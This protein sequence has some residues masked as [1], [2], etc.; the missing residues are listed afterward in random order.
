MLHVTPEAPTSADAEPP[1]PRLKQLALKGSAYEIASFGISQAIRLGSNILLTRL[2]APE[3]FGLA[4]MI[5]MVNYGLIMLSDLGTGPSVVQS[6]HGDEPDYLNTAWTMHVMRGAALFC[7]SVLAAWPIAW[8]YD[9]PLLGPVLAV[10]SIGVLF[11]GFE[12]TALLTLLRRVDSRRLALLDLT[13]Q[14]VGIGVTIIGAYFTRSVWAIVAGLLATGASKTLL[15]HFYLDVGY[16]NRFFWSKEA[17]QRIVRFGRWIFFASLVTFFSSQVDRMVLGKLLGLAELGVYAVA[18]SLAEVGMMLVQRLTSQILFPIL[19]RVHREQPDRVSNVFYRARL[20]LDALSLPAAGALFVLA[21]WVIDLLYDD[22]Y[23]DASWMLSVLTLRITISCMVVPMETCLFALGGAHFGLMKS[24]CKLGAMAVGLPIGYHYFGLAGIV[25]ATA[26]S[27]LPA[28]L[29]L[30][31]AFARR[32][33]LKVHREL[34]VPVLFTLGVLLGY[35]VSAVLE[36][37]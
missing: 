2:L 36:A 29:V 33:L 3:A 17:A 5:N 24:L 8:L 26:L 27:D 7:I 15:S 20:G 1:K 22:R 6:P 37:L 11:S 23:A 16:K 28:L 4:A 12:S 14:L 32:K 30:F 21:P 10:S 13:L 31:P 35:G 19:S 9:E 25:W 18:V 34:L